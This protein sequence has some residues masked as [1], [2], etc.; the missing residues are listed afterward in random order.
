MRAAARPGSTPMAVLEKRMDLHGKVAV[1]TGASSGI[2]EATVRRLDAAG[3]TVVAVARRAD[4]LEALAASGRAITA[5]PADVT[6]PDQVQALA[7]AVRQNH[8]ACHV[9]VNNAGFTRRERFTRTAGED[10]IEDFEAVLDVN[11]YGAL[12]CMLAFEDLL[13]ASAPSRVVNV[14]SVAGKLGVG[15]ASYVTSKFALVGVS[16]AVRT[17]WLPRGISVCQ[18]N[19]GFTRTEGFPQEDLLAGPFGRLVIT[20]DEVA[21]VVVEVAASG[22]AERTVPRWYRPLVVARHIAARPFWAITR[23][24]M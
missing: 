7:E 6:D 4:R 21:K 8:G 11:L 17:E 3:M 5:H 18:V 20:P 22:A 12:R 1:V 10:P 23:R 2:G 15:P 16:E 13:A 19:P 9:L 24:L 14:A